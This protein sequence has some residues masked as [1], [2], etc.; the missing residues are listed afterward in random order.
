MSK[1]VRKQ[2]LC[3]AARDGDVQQI[4]RLLGQGA[5]IDAAAA[6]YPWCPTLPGPLNTVVLWSGDEA[7]STNEVPLT[8]LIWASRNGHT[9]CVKVL[10]ERGAEVNMQNEGFEQGLETLHT[11]VQYTVSI[12]VLSMSPLICMSPLS[13]LTERHFNNGDGGTALMW[14]SG[15]GHMECVKVL[16]DRGADVNMQDK[17][18]WTALMKA[19]KSGHMEC[20]KVLLDTVTPGLSSSLSTSVSFIFHSLLVFCLLYL[21]LL[22]FGFVHLHVFRTA[23]ASMSAST[24]STLVNMSSTTANTSYT[25]ANNSTAAFTSSTA[26]NTP[27]LSPPP[28]R[29]PQPLPASRAPPP[30]RLLPP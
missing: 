2:K 16:L 7:Q 21:L 9:E 28:P 13:T 12:Q 11:P 29:A 20:V 17:N 26:A 3:E 25:F 6:F 8:P 30:S 19:S 23:S 18:G 5:D 4:I 10:L 14:A 22:L 1:E 15:W 27:P 24:I